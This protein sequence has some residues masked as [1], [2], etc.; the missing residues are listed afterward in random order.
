MPRF[1]ISNYGF[2]VIPL[3][4]FAVFGVAFKIFDIWPFGTAIIAS[5]DML[6]QICPILEHFFDVFQ[7]ESGL[8]HTFH[9]GSGMDMFG[10][11]AYCAV[12]P[13]TFMFL[14]AGKAGSLHMVSIVLPLKF[15]CIAISAFIFLRRYFKGFPQY[16]QIVLAILYACSGYAYVANTY[17]IWMDIMMYMPL[18]G[19]GI[20][21]FSKKGS[22]RLMVIGLALSIYACFSIV[23]FSFL[24]LFPVLVCYVLI[25]KKRE[26]WGVFLSKLCLAFVVSVAVA[27]PVLLPSLMAYTKAGRNTGLFSRVFEIMSE[28][29]VLEGELNIHLYEKFAY[30]FCDSTFIALT[31][32]YFMRSKKGDKLALF[33]L[34]ALVYLLIPCIVDESM[35]LLNMG[36]Y[37][38][39]ALRFGFLFSF[40][41]LFVSAKAIEQITEDKLDERKI[42]KTGSNISLV[43]VAVLTTLVALFSIRFFKFIIDGEYKNSKLV[44]AVFGTGGEAEPFADFF[45]LFA[46]SEGGCE[47]T[48]V[49]FLVVLLVFTVTAILVW[50]KLVKVKDVACYLCVIALSQTVFFN[51]SLVKGDRQSGSYQ[52]FEYYSEMI[53]EIDKIEDDEYYRL[54]NYKYYISS[55]S[56]II[57]GNYSNTFFSSMADAKNITSAKFFGYGGRV[58]IR[59]SRLKRM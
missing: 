45:P 55:D 8:L 52:K 39:Y 59:L 44:S 14:L 19:A 49:L 57:L 6:A 36:S 3:F 31:V 58:F 27:L 22:I 11:L 48:A 43:V 54:K 41:F 5:Y 9:V 25:C 40:Y 56:P 24:T 33:L 1:L 30:I 13:F 10:I 18:L 15:A 47:V 42:S 34:V 12:S 53:E 4:I 26:E 29:K 46:H 20:I 28:Q 38:S 51:F 35:L 7:G 21:E 50:T 32:I 16:V 17:I 37:Y 2:F 23:C